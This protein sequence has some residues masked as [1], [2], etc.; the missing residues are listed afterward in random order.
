MK[1]NI[2]VGFSIL[3]LL[4]GLFCSCSQKENIRENDLQ[5]VE[6]RLDTMSHLFNDTT[7]PRCDF[8]L[9]M[10]YPA[11]AASE[12]ELQKVQRIFVTDF[13]GDKYAAETPVNAATAYLKEYLV[14]Y[15]QLEEDYSKFTEIDPEGMSNAW[16]NYE[17]F[18][19][20]SI[21][22]NAAHLLSY[23]I[24]MYTYTGGAHGMQSQMNHVLDLREVTP[25]VLSDIFSEDN[26]PTVNQL[27]IDRIAR[28]RGY[29]NPAQLGEDGFFSIEEVQATDNFLVDANGIT[30]IYN[31]YEIA[32]YAA[33]SITVSLDWDILSTYIREDSPVSLLAKGSASR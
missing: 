2:S 32:V 10:E 14:N 23:T 21:A 7:K 17:E 4:L 5:F 28:D 16:M 13:F 33:G 6:F 22:F 9:S 19:S 20:S 30:W 1:K 3:S 8:R 26:L 31:P 11:Q 24:T 27:I 18:L 15:H 12:E 29:S 25:V